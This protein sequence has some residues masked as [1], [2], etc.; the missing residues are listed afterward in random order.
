[1]EGSAA[2]KRVL[3]LSGSYSWSLQTSRALRGIDLRIALLSSTAK[4]RTASAWK[5]ARR[6]FT[7]AVILRRHESSVVAVWSSY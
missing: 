5:I 1:M 4:F 2:E 7:A 3:D 6:K